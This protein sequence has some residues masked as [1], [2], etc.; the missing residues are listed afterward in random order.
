MRVSVICLL[1]VSLPVLGQQPLGDGLEHL[2]Q[3]ISTSA[4]REQKQRIA[5]LAFHELD[6][7]PTIMGSYVAEELTTR[8]VQAQFRVVERHLLTSVLGE[9]KM[10]QSGVFDPS[11][12]KAIGRIAG[13]DAII[14]GTIT[15][16]GGYVAVHCRLIDTRT[17][18]VF[19]AAHTKIRRDSDVA[20]G[21]EIARPA[22]GIVPAGNLSR[23][24]AGA[25]R[26]TLQSAVRVE[27]GVRCT[28]QFQNT[29]ARKPLAV[30]LNAEAWE[31]GVPR[32]A[33]TS[34]GTLRLLTRL[35]SDKG[36]V[37][38]L[39]A[40]DV[41]GVGVL[42]VG[43]KG[44]DG[45]ESYEPSEVAR[46]LQLRDRLGRDT[47]DPEDGE[48]SQADSVGAGGRNYTFG[49]GGNVSPMRFFPY[50]G[51]RFL[52]GG[53]TTIPAGGTATA[54]LI[55]IP[56]GDTKNAAGVLQLNAE[57]V[58]GTPMRSYRVHTL[59]MN[60]IRVQP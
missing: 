22:E 34:T 37:W 42:R 40:E 39:N 8:L 26:A 9:L 56:T 47:D 2:A 10:Q 13:V 48:Y 44:R 28:I 7:R 50:Q 31:D 38:M 14:T 27:R 18:E 23:A 1:L 16:F 17:G 43:V 33:R 12:A 52:S 32:R 59:V 49:S 55:F 15:D 3:Q 58:A 24:T 30:A 53:V 21:L 11:T 25:L 19:A 41:D 35:V 46:L 60:G 4:L 54:T 6:G 57:I 5:V 51:N 29:D 20:M 45:R 36:G